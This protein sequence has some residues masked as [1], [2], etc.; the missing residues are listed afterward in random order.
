MRTSTKTLPPRTP[1]EEL[2]PQRL[3]KKRDISLFNI[4]C[5]EAIAESA[6]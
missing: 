4:F 6:V 5:E 3:R 1:Q 2:L